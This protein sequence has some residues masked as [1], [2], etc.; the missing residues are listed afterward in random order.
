VEGT[1]A[2]FIE[3]K[4]ETEAKTVKW[5]LITETDSLQI[6]QLDGGKTL[7][8]VAKYAGTYKLLAYTAAG[9][10]PSDPV[11]C[12]LI[13]SGEGPSPPP[14]PPPTEAL[15]R[16]L[17]GAFNSDSITVDKV[18]KLS[19]L[20]ALYKAGLE[21]TLNDKNVK[22]VGQFVTVMHNSAQNLLGDDLK[23]LRT[24]IKDELNKTLPKEPG[25]ELD[26]ATKDLISKEFNK[27]IDALGKV[28]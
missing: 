14:P 8:V 20:Q 7:W 19:T 24:V 1:T 22:T 10:V 23:G 9:D 21:N 12:V 3:I 26:S 27:I 25:K 6:K 15:V 11:F 2:S 28:K 18:K 17:Q 13:V 4:A 5:V 16:E